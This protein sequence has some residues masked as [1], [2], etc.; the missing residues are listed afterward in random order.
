MHTDASELKIDLG[1]V[2]LGADSIVLMEFARQVS[3]PYGTR[4]TVR[5][6]LEQHPTLAALSRHLKSLPIPSET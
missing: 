4:L 1:F 2:E 3:A 5:Q 6:L